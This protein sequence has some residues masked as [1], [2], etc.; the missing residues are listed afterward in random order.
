MLTNHGGCA[1]TSVEKHYPLFVRACGLYHSFT[2]HIVLELSL[3]A[4]ALHQ[5]LPLPRRPAPNQQA[6]E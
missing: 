2:P 3:T 6:K 4:S 5:F 1:D